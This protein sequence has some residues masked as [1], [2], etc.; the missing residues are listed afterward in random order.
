[1]SKV[2]GIIAEYNP[3]HNG[4]LYHIKKSIEETGASSV[5][6][7][8]SGNFVQRGNTSIVD[9]WTKTKMALANGVDLVLE[10]PTIYSVS[11]AENF[12]E[13]AIR[14]LDSLKIV[15]TISFGMEAKDIASLNNIA[16]VL[17]TEPKEYTTILEHE[18]RKGVSFPKARENAV[19]MY[20]N[21]IK[22]YAN[23][24]TGSNNILAIEYLK[25]IKKLKSKLNPIG[26][27]REKVLYNDEI[28]IDDFAS[29]TAIRKMIATGQFSD[30]QKVMPKSSYALLA[31]ELRKGHYVLDLSKFQKEII[32]NLRKMSV[33]E[34]AQLVDVSEGLENAIKNAANSSNNLVDFVNIVK[35]KR[36]TQTRIQRILIYALLGITNSKMLAFK[37]AVPYARVLGFNENGKQLI[38]QI[39]KK[40]KKV[41]IVTS[42]KKYMDESKNKVLKEMLETDILATN[43]YTLGYEKDSW[44][45]LD[46]TNKLVTM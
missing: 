39:A 21:D 32:Y 41:Q 34:I 15:D 24:L 13:G 30:I 18:L 2:L 27:R 20:L 46:Y 23:I 25:A 38:S 9:K 42:V 11:S 40:N 10:L 28:I 36:Y 4:H 29:A 37:K 45:N 16:N 44:S 14:L 7:V 8:M 12:A 6:C 35:S 1:M 33:E 31:D 26:I 22:Q 5:I 43:V 19:M 3:F 17:Y